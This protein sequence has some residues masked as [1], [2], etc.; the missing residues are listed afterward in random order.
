MKLTKSWLDKLT[1]FEITTD[2]LVEQLTMAGLEVDSVKPIAGDFNGVVVG[3]VL[4][5]KKHPDADKLNVCQVNVGDKEPLN[6][7]CGA[8]NVKPGLKV[9]VALVGAKLPGDFEIKKAKLRGVESAGMICSESELGLA[10]SSTEIMELPDDAP[11]GTDIRKYLDLDDSAIEIELTTNRGDCLSVNGIA[12]EVAAINRF[13]LDPIKI[14]TYEDN[15]DLFEVEIE[16]KDFCP[17]YC[18]RI[19]R[20]VR[21]DF[22]TPFWMQERLRRIGEESISPVVDV[23]NYVMYELGQPIHAFDLKKLDKKIKVRYAKQNEY[24]KLLDDSELKLSSN[25]AVIADN[26]KPVAFAGVMGGLDSGVYEDTTDIFLESAY[27]V[28]EKLSGVARSYGIQ[29]DA[30]HRYERGV[31]PKLQLAA[32]NYATSLI[33]E[34]CGGTP[35]G[36]VEVTEPQFLPEIKTVYLPRKSVKDIIGIEID[37][38]E[39]VNILEHLDMKVEPAKD[40]WNVVPPSWR[41]D[42]GIKEDLVEEIARI[43]DYHRIPEQEIIAE[44]E[45]HPDIYDRKHIYKIYDLMEG[46]GYNE[47]ISYSFVDKKIQSLFDPYSHYVSLANP[48]SSE[49]DVMRTMLWPGLIEALKYNLKRQQQRVRLFE[50]G[51]RF[52]KENKRDL[53]QIQSIAGVVSGNLY[54]EQ[55]GISQKE[56][57]DFYDVKN[58]VAAL[59]KLF[60]YDQEIEYVVRSN[61]ALH[62]LRSAEVYVDGNSVGFVG[63]LHPSIKQ[64]LGLTKQTMLFELDLSIIINNKKKAFK[65]ISR[66]PKIQR[67]IAITIGKDIT[68]SKI[69]EKIVDISGELLQNVAVFDI[70][71]NENIG[72]DKQSMAI[73]LDFQSVDR[74]LVDT[75][76]DN[77][78]DQ[79]ILMLKQTFN[80]SLRG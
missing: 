62:P 74:T 70:Y 46:L 78:V 56:Q 19:I 59:L 43:Y 80:A 67:D 68:W 55:W 30:S 23:T 21:N 52:V 35:C 27:F 13:K 77:L 79:I 32:L 66:F 41:F 38:N 54:P 44:I 73:R 48:M 50:I 53:K 18:G 9:A 64:E 12:R 57:T 39:I 40:G 72:L 42:I 1:K 61:D 45:T 29:T 15:N 8:K 2:D 75:E 47:I 6:I 60:G 3:E 49:M 24:L 76:V 14:P 20:G 37:D 11:V 28:P 34:I 17:H 10:E 58:T 4:E 25:H 69:R 31:D 71:H 7:V 33:I 36:V 63:Q 16:A 65:P 22:K 51:L 26:D 5:A